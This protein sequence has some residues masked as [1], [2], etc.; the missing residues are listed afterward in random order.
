VK[1]DIQVVFFVRHLAREPTANNLERFQGH[2]ENME[3]RRRRKKKKVTRGKRRT[4]V[5]LVGRGITQ[6][7]T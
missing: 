4:L 6:F 5:T 2:W 1:N 7:I 3:R